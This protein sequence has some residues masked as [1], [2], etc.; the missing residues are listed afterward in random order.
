MNRMVRAKGRG[1]KTR[2]HPRQGELML[3]PPVPIKYTK[4]ARGEFFGR[5]INDA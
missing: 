2:F 3:L 5:E 1:K 4:A